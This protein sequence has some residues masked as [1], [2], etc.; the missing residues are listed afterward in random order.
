MRLW[1]YAEIDAKV[2]KDTDTKDENFISPTEM[3]GYC[4]EAIDEAEAEILTLYEDY[5]LT[6]E[7][8]SLVE[9]T[10]NYD[11]PS[12][13]YAQKIRS[14]IYS[15]G[16]NT[17]YEIKP[18]SNLQ[19]FLKIAEGQMAG[20][21]AEDYRYFLKNSATEG[22][23]L[24]LVPESRETSATV[25]TL[26]YIRNALRVTA[27]SD[28]IDIPEFANFILAY[29]KARCRAK[30]ENGVIPGDAAA[31]VEQQRKMMVDTLKGRVPDDNNQIPMDLSIYQEHS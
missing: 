7:A 21:E 24:V 23:Q 18:I 22:N 4:N 25:A 31:Q 16:A 14:I 26:W 15:D 29:M 20:G 3:M 11:L 2:R 27:S 1:T 6:S 13:I 19:K 12:D 30:E 9:G 28:E 10:A 8:L 5:F 17:L